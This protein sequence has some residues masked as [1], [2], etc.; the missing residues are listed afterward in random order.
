MNPISSLVF[1][2]LLTVFPT[3]ILC[4]TPLVEQA[5]G[6][7]I[8]KVLCL[9]TFVP[10]PAAKAATD[11]LTLA[12]ISLKHLETKA[13]DVDTEIIKQKNSA[14]DEGLKQAL[15]SCSD[16]YLTVVEKLQA[17]GVSLADSNYVSVKDW[18]S[19]ATVN[20]QRCDQVFQGKPFK[21]PISESTTT[22]SQLQNNAEAI[23]SHLP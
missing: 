17:A 10:D 2:L 22:L 16:Y 1:V 21:S 7:T 19:E 11:L 14:K 18:M 6:Y 4:Q 8:Y 5:C 15:S 3:Q 20:R 12:K 13:S 23:I 9:E